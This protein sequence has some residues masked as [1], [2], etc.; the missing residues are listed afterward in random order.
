MSS[1]RRVF[2]SGGPPQLS[3]AA[4]VDS[5][6]GALHIV[7]QTTGLNGNEIH[8]QRRF[9]ASG[10]PNPFDDI[11]EARGESI[12]DVTLARDAEGGLHLAFGTVGSGVLQVRYKL[13]QQGIGWDRVSTEVTLPSDGSSSR[14]AVLAASPRELSV[15]YAGFIGGLPTFM[16]RRRDLNPTVTTSVGTT[17]HSR[18]T[19][20]AVTPNP[21]RAGA[22]L[23]LRG[24]GTPTADRLELFDLA[25]RRMSTLPIVRDGE[26]WTAQL[27][28]GETANWRSGVYLV[29][30]KGTRATH[31]RVVL[32]R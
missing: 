13:W 12:Q 8:H 19:P 2:E 15:L 14:P 23:V 30:V 26:T 22:G 17:P 16:E 7:W 6:T 29:R 11:I 5:A 24:A 28:P 21:V 18:S 9:P 20:I 32:I 31:S 1:K 25:G 27:R 4:V 3:P 10:Q